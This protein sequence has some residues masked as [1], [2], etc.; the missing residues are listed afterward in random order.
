MNNGV[1]R[2]AGEVGGEGVFE[3][4]F[5]EGGAVPALNTVRDGHQR[6]T[7]H[8]GDGVGICEDGLNG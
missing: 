3:H 4:T 6:V 7:A 8:S 1:W 5:G 2:L